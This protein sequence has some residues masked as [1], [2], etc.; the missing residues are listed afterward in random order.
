LA[1]LRFIKRKNY[2]KHISKIHA[3]KPFP[4]QHSLLFS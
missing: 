4:E 3:K 2:W 1:D